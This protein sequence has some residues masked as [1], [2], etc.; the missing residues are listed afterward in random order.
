MIIVDY[1]CPACD[2]I[3]EH[4]VS[5]PAPPTMQC[6]ACRAPAQRRFSAVGLSGRA[7]QR[8]ESK[9]AT[10][11]RA[12]CLDNRDVPGLC[13]MTPDAARTWVARARR[14]NR[15]LDRELERQERNLAE[16]AGHVVDPVS[17]DHGHAHGPGQTHAHAAPSAPGAAGSA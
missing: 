1:R 14:D 17:H 7:A 12:L 6:P 4:F 8:V 10:S 16:T 3:S 5:N 15:S 9:P 13:H 2:G 11:D